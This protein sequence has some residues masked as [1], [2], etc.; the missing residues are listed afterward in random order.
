[1]ERNRLLKK[2]I[3]SFEEYE[4]LVKDGVQ[5]D[6]LAKRI[7]RAI[8]YIELLKQT[9]NSNRA[10]NNM[11]LVDSETLLEILKGEQID[12]K[13]HVFDLMEG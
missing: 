7:D 13:N 10:K 3:I 12:D 9:D 8:E 6:I 11:I 4:R 5:K 1:M 2:A